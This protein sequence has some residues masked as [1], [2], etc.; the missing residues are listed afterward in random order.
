MVNPEQWLL[1]FDR[2]DSLPWLCLDDG[3]DNDV[4]DQITKSV[5]VHRTDLEKY[6][7][8]LLPSQFRMREWH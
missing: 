8:V 6:H 2:I 7:F 3:C 4:D 1:D 5:P